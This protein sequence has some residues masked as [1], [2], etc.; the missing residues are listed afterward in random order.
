[1]KRLLVFP[2]ILI[3]LLGFSGCSNS[4]MIGAF[5]TTTNHKMSAS[6]IRFSGTNDK[7]LTVKE[8]E[9]IEISVKIKTKSGS[10]DAYIYNE[11]KEYSYEGEDIP[12]SS[13]TVTLTEPG[14]YSIKVD[15]DKHKGSY[16]F[17]W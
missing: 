2:L 8:G 17:S 9:T 13:F 1:M 16:S 6:Y 5:E 15:A 10:I 12:T 4:F 11:D 7:E 14:D 3:M